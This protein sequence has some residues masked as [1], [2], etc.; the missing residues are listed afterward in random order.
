MTAF[1]EKKLRDDK[2]W[3]VIGLRSDS[4]IIQELVAN[5]YSRVPALTS[6]VDANINLSAFGI[7]LDISKKSPV[8]RC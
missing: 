1:I 8:A 2:D 4:D 5:L 3:I 7:G 6:F